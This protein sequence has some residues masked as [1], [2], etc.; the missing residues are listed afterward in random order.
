MIRTSSKPVSD[1]TNRLNEDLLAEEPSCRYKRLNRANSPNSWICADRFQESRLWFR[2][3][4]R[5]WIQTPRVR[6]PQ[7]QTRLLAQVL[8][9]ASNPQCHSI[10]CAGPY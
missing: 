2:S 1:L 10:P 7:F 9:P 3:K 8:D 6:L 5:C 4:L